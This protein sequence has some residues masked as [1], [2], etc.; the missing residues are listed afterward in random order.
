MIQEKPSPALPSDI[1]HNKEEKTNAIFCSFMFKYCVGSQ[2]L[3]GLCVMC[4]KL[5]IKYV[6][7]VLQMAPKT[8][9]LFSNRLP[10]VDQTDTPLSTHVIS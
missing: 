2:T 5:K 1:H 6:I 9:G 7:V 4:G 10:L 3:K 8:I